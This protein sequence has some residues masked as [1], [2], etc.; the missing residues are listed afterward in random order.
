MWRVFV[1]AKSFRQ[2]KPNRLEILLITSLYYTTICKKKLFSCN[3]LKNWPNQSILI[4][5]VAHKNWYLNAI[6]SMLFNA[7]SCSMFNASSC[8]AVWCSMRLAVRCLMRL[9][10]RCSMRLAVRW[11]IFN[12][13]FLTLPSSFFCFVWWIYTWLKIPKFVNNHG[14]NCAKK[15]KSQNMWWAC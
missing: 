3:F 8:L 11:L 1:R 6:V 7:S 10:V 12:F 14:G 4:F 13:R 9:A 15:S 5:S 2:K